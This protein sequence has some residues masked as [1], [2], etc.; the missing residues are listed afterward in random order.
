MNYFTTLNGQAIDISSLTNDERSFLARALEAVENANVTKDDMLALIYGDDN[1]ILDREFI[2]GRP[3]VTP[4]V[5]AHPAYHVLTDL[6]DQKRIKLGQLDLA[7]AQAAY[8]IDVPTAALQLGITQ[9]AIRTAIDARKLSAVLRNGQWWIHPQALTTYEVSKR[10]RPGKPD[11]LVRYV[12]GSAAGMSFSLKCD[13][14]IQRSAKIGNKTTGYL[15]PGWKRA[16]VRTTTEQGTR[17][18]LIEPTT[19]IETIPLGEFQISGGF[20]IVK[21]YNAT[22]AAATAWKEFKVLQAG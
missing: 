22:P 15:L 7:A 2:P 5:L 6:L 12:I 4:K 20:K 13:G 3:M 11:N 21:K 14:S 17:A 10:G 9:Q 8:T 16:I 1:P 19:D 18:F